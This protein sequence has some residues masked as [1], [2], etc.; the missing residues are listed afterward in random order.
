VSWS[1]VPGDSPLREIVSSPR[2]LSVNGD[3][4]NL[5]PG[6][7]GSISLIYDSAGPFQ[8]AVLAF[9][10]KYSGDESISSL[11]L[12]FSFGELIDYEEAGSGFRSRAIA[13]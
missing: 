6:H 1:D 9:F 5:R 13:P 2:Q 11:S 3:S 10:N 7:E 12:L 4:Y 8:I